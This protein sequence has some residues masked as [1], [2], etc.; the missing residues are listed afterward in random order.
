MPGKAA[1]GGRLSSIHI[2]PFI[3]DG[4]GPTLDQQ[5]LSIGPSIPQLNM[6]TGGMALSSQP[7]NLFVL[8]PRQVKRL[9]PWALAN[10]RNDTQANRQQLP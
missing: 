8:L 2:R 1:G 5:V 6:M 7:S 9:A 4:V 3:C 10:R